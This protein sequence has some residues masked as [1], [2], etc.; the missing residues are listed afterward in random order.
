MSAVRSCSSCSRRRRLSTVRANAARTAAPRVATTSPSKKNPM[1]SS[2]FVLREMAN[3]AGG[4][5]YAAMSV[6]PMMAT[7][8]GPNPARTALAR[9]RQKEVRPGRSERGD[10]ELQPSDGEGEHDGKAVP[11]RPRPVRPKQAKRKIEKPVLRRLHAR[12]ASRAMPSVTLPDRASRKFRAG[13]V[14]V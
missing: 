14:E 3:P 10:R 6:V 2:P 11:H 13:G 7:S 8:A 9:N 5:K 12:D 1:T 4:V